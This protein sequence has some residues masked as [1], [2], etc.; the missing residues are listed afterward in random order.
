MT[1]MRRG[2]NMFEIDPNLQD[3][4]EQGI[5]N[6]GSNLSGV[7]SKCSWEEPTED[8]EDDKENRLAEGERRGSNDTIVRPQISA[9]GKH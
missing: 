2:E 1:D 7:S 6:E 3:K 8:G 4:V 9:F 5:I